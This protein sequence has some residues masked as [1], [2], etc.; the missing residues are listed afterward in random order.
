M[1][2]RGRGNIGED[3][4]AEFLEKN[5]YKILERNYSVRGGEIDIIAQKNDILA[6]VEVKTRSKKFITDGES[7]VDDNKRRLIIKTA[8]IF[9]DGYKVRSG[10]VF[11]RFDVVSVVVENEKIISAKYYPGA[12]DSTNI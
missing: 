1:S 11:C 12:F 8:G 7:A 6:F 4:A 3:A 2:K 9:Y 5:G 10:D